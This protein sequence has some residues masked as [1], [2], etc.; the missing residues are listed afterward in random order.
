MGCRGK[1]QIE[2]LKVGA[3]Q[4]AQSSIVI[5]QQN[6]AFR[7]HSAPPSAI[8]IA[9]KYKVLAGYKMIQAVT[10]LK[11][12]ASPARLSWQASKF[13]TSAWEG[14]TMLKLITNSKQL[15]D[16]R[17]EALLLLAALMIPLSAFSGLVGF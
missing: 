8:V 2:T 10:P 6:P 7:C 14:R 1:L 5:Y 15:L 3:Q 9:K 17:D 4:L 12:L 11:G 16:G 13:N